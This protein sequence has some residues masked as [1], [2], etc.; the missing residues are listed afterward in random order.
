M[1][2]EAEIWE[3]GRRSGGD[4]KKE[5]AAYTGRDEC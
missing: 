3:G 5:D 1:C 4:F 2:V